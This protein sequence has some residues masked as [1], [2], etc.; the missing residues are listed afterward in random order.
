MTQQLQQTDFAVEISGV[1]VAYGDVIALDGVNLELTHGRV[2]GLVG[3]NGSGKSTLFKSLMGMVR[4]TAGTVQING[5]T[6]EIARSAGVVSYMPQSENVDWDFPVRV[7][8]VVM[9]GR[10]GLMNRFRRVRPVDRAAVADALEQVQLTAFADRQ[11]G[12]LSGGQRKRA[13]LARAIAQQAS[14]L[15]L[16]EP[17]A[18]VDKPSEQ[19]IIELL[20][21]L[22]L[23][24]RTIMVSTHDLEGLPTLADDVVLLHQRVL[25]HG[26]PAEVLR[27]AVLGLAFGAIR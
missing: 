2:H 7:R 15:L 16:D 1:R 26:S 14:L 21:D 8:D 12:K 22:A 20:R 5:L 17:F 9:M 19:T 27:P 13:F 3:M 11:I 4:L 10:Y 23:Q 25:A 18:G 6:P 24:G